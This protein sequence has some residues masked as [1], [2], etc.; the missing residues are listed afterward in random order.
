MIPKKQ[1]FLL[2]F[3][4]IEELEGASCVSR[5]PPK[6]RIEARKAKNP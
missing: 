2:T 3:G 5:N 1:R 6:L 4:P